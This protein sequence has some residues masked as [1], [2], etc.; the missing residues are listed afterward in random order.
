MNK[1]ETKKFMI[2]LCAV[3]VTVCVLIGVFAQS[4]VKNRDESVDT[5]VKYFGLMN[6]EDTNIEV[7]ITKAEREKEYQLRPELSDD[8]AIQLSAMIDKYLGIGDFDSLDKY[9]RGIIEKYRDVEDSPVSIEEL[10]T[11]RADIALTVNMN[12][13]SSVSLMQSYRDPRMRRLY[14]SIDFLKQAH[15]EMHI[16][17]T[18]K[19]TPISCKY[20]SVKHGDSLMLPPPSDGNIQMEEIEL[21]GEEKDLWIQTLNQTSELVIYTDVKIYK[22]KL[23]GCELR[24]VIGYR[25]NSDTWGAY[26]IYSEDERTEGVFQTALEMQR[27]EG[28]GLVSEETMDT[29]FVYGDL[30]EER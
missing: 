8:I 13:T 5:E 14:V 25:L 6:G 1:E 30:S 26:K 19:F 3:G 29:E 28:E 15:S 20:K 16:F 4:I 23:Y 10:E 17:L 7:P 18:Y 21:S 2:V 11:M 22:C 9:L 27:L 24:F 12:S